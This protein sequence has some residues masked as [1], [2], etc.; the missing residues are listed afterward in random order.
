MW[1]AKMEGLWSEAG[2]SKKVHKI[3]GMVSHACHPSYRGGRR[4]IITIQYPEQ[5]CETLPEN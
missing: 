5:N 4:G 1:E 2:L 3:M